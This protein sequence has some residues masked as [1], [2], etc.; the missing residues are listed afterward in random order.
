[1][2][3]DT[4]AYGHVVRDSNR[5]QVYVLSLPWDATNGRLDRVNVVPLL[6]DHH[7]FLVSSWITMQH[8]FVSNTCHYIGPSS[9][10]LIP[11]TSTHLVT[12]L[13]F[14]D[15][16]KPSHQDIHHYHHLFTNS[17]ARY[18]SLALPDQDI[19][20][21]GSLRRITFLPDITHRYPASSSCVPS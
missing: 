14:L 12:H 10:H 1:M 15:R 5:D 8:S 7:R 20:V 16:S 2:A 19:P 11:R 18:P 6:R 13:S 21:P 4:H 3:L 9:T 17:P